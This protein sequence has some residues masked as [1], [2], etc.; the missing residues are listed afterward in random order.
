[1]GLRLFLGVFP[2]VEILRS[3]E[4]ALE[5]FPKGERGVRWTTTSQR[6]VTLF[7]LGDVSEDRLEGLMGMV[8]AP[9]ADVPP[10]EA[11]LRGL[12]AFPD[13]R[14]PKTIFVPAF[15]PA[16]GWRCLTEALRPGLDGLGFQ[17]ETKSFEPHLTLVRVKDP[18]AV[19]GLLMDLQKVLG[20]F[21]AS[22]TVDRF[23]LVASRLEPQGA[24]YE[25]LRTYQ[26]EKAE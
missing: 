15:S 17:L 21:E 26:L 13:L 10:F 12:G 11:T 6:H 7:F 2:P 25:T 18:G 20:C 14:S 5:G 19:R 1:V 3:L 22:W 16:D 9:A 23:S 8:A 4:D 24:R